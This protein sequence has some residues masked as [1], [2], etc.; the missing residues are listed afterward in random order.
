M[1][2]KK[3]LRHQLI[4]FLFNRKNA[5]NVYI[6]YLYVRYSFVIQF[7]LARIQVHSH[8]C[9]LLA[10]H[11]IS[12]LSFEIYKLIIESLTH[13]MLSRCLFLFP[14]SISMRISSFSYQ[15][16][17]E[18]EINRGLIFLQKSQT[19]SQT[20]KI[21]NSTLLI[22]PSLISFYYTSLLMPLRLKI[23]QYYQSEF[24]MNTHKFYFFV[25]L[26]CLLLVWFFKLWRCQFYYPILYS[27]L[28]YF[29]PN[30]WKERKQLLNEIVW[31]N[32]KVNV[33]YF[34]FF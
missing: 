20:M 12:Q 8:W 3:T 5:K 1:N 19:F 2:H 6:S 34:T 23:I 9:E 33:K 25:F 14:L 18:L 26:F 21:F 27:F 28:S 7:H 22:Y 11:S 15:I 4:W 30:I 24:R 17:F 13:Q 31:L 16:I 32:V 10:F 29:S